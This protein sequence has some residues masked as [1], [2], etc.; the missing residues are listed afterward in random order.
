MKMAQAK[1]I[2][3]KITK[4]LISLLFIWI[5]LAAVFGIYAYLFAWRPLEHLNPSHSNAEQH[6]AQI[7][8]NQQYGEKAATHDRPF[9]LEMDVPGKG[10]IMLYGSEH[11]KNPKDPQI[12]DISKRW[13]H[14]KPTVALCESRLGVFF[15]GLMNPVKT[16]AE[17]GIVHALA[18]QSDIPTYTWEPPITLQ[19]QHLLKDYSKEQVALRFILTP[20]FS[21]L[22]FGRPE[23]PDA[24]VESIRKKRNQ[25]PGIENAFPNMQAIQSTWDHYFPKGPDWRTVSDAYELPG[26][27]NGMDANIIRDR[28]FFAILLELVSKGERVF[29][30]AGSSHA[31]KLEPALT[32]AFKQFLPIDQNPPSELED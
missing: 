1:S 30:I 11:T 2:P 12:K 28:H 31:V 18:R 10:A 3:Q 8:N 5:C 32:K 26:F 20:Y 27:L 22:R 4:C 15:P 14:F 23:N 19:L 13:Q 21:N 29:A 9:I 17:P 24:M 7:L 6:F 16:F 25:W